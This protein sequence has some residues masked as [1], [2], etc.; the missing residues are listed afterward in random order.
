MK[1]RLLTAFLALTLAM[2]C[3]MPALAE[4]SAS[5]P[6]PTPG[7]TPAAEQSLDADSSVQTPEAESPTYYPY[8]VATEVDGAQ[9]L[10]VMRYRVPAGI[11]A[12][13]LT[14]NDLTRMGEP[15]TL[16]AVT[17]TPEDVTT[18]EKNAQQ[19]FSVSVYS[20]I[21]EEARSEVKET[22]DYK[23]EDGFTGTLTL[24]DLS[25]ADE[26]QENGTYIAT[27]QYAGTASRSLAGDISYELIYA[28]VN[29]PAAEAA[30]QEN[31]SDVL[32][33]MMMVSLALFILTCILMLLHQ[34]VAL[35]LRQDGPAKKAKQAPAAPAHQKKQ[36]IYVPSS[37][38]VVG[39]KGDDDDEK[40]D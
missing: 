4:E 31:S 21:P 22:I 7:P 40:L 24:S 39:G 38:I 30:V 18:E 20:N 1:Q 2:G 29:P 26:M 14:R 6:T 8:E 5:A 33:L 12:E 25:I 10:V 17:E 16:W 15:Y 19:S 27:V 3:C 9:T 35:R 36:K 37:D 34:S 13:E 32:L 11:T 28:P 23:D